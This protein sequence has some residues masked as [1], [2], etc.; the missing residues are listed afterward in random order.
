MAA[1]FQRTGVIRVD[2]IEELFDVAQVVGS[3]PLGNGLRVAVLSNAGGPAVLAVDACES[4]GLQ[5]PEFSAELKCGS[6][7]FV[8]VTA[9]PATR[10]TSAQRQAPRC[11]NKS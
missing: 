10:S 1:L 7:I 5:V 9:G 3:Q 11:T 6:R 2:T 8:P 4:N